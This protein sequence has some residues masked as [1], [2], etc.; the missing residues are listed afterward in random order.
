MFTTEMVSLNKL[1]SV[2]EYGVN[3][4]SPY[5]AELV[6][7]TPE[8]SIEIQEALGADI[9]MQLDHVVHVLTTGSIVEQAMKRSIRYEKEETRWLDRCKKT[10]TRLDQALFP[11][12][13]GGL[14]VVLRK[15]CIT[16][17]IKRAELGIAIGGL[18]GGEEKSQ[19]WKIV[20]FCC[21]SLPPH[22]PRYLMG[23]GFPVDM[24]ICSLLGVDMFDCVYPTRTAR[25]G[26]ALVRHGGLLNLSHQKFA[27]DFR[28]IEDDCDCHTCKTYT[29]AFIH[30]IVNKETVGCHL[31]TVHNIRYQLRLMEELRRAIDSDN[32]QQFLEKFLCDNYLED[33][34]PQWVRDAVGFMGFKLFPDVTLG[35]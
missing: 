25:F 31:L 35:T 33:P 14:D 24:V 30:M 3:F 4:E 10:Q 29:R 6:T 2:D 11:I 16:E 32:V 13:Q 28:P 19:F 5:T 21:E 20:A 34:I 22:L 15:D 23:V 12:I 1:M 18:S 9:M 27:A 17:M 7:L 8:M 26:T